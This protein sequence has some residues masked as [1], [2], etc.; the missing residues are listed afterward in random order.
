MTPVMKRDEP[1]KNGKVHIVGAGPGDPELITVKGAR[2][3]A[4]ADLVIYAG[5][6]VCEEILK[7]CREGCTLRDSAGIKIGRA[8]V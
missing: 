8:H 1:V 7:H 5:S 4:S 3:L 6:L 2:L